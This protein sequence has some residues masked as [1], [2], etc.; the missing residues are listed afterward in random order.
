MLSPREI[1]ALPDSLVALLS[2]LDSDLAREAAR[3]AVTGATPQQVTA[4]LEAIGADYTLRTQR[5]AARVVSGGVAKAEKRLEPA[6]SRAAASGL[7]REVADTV[8][9]RVAAQ[10]MRLASAEALTLKSRAVE[11]TIGVVRE[12]VERGGVQ[13][14][15]GQLTRQE[16]VAQAVDAIGSTATRFTYNGRSIE[17]ESAVRQTIG[18]MAHRAVGD[19]AYQRMTEVGVQQVYVTQ[20]MGARP[21]HAE[22]QGKVYGFPEELEEV[23]G[24]PSDS[25]G[26]MGVNCRHS[27]YATFTDDDGDF[28]ERIDEA[29]NAE[30]Y[31]ATQRQRLAERNIRRYKRRL[32]AS[33]GGLDADPT[34][35]LLAKQVDRDKALVKKWQAEA[36]TNARTNNLTRRYASEKPLQ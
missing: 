34:N 5:E 25:L 29:E 6:L 10:A 30:V 33:E 12:A 22:W 3:L 32:S 4:R 13:V 1:Q 18:S 36:R 15:S 21:E 24:Y 9:R 23:T 17:L 35:A 11:A 28:P 8:S 14:A 19:Y 31:E 20:H 26:L 2:D 27:F 16:A 7:V